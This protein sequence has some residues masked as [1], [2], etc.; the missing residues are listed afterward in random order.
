MSDPDLTLVE[1]DALL[2]ELS[3]RFDSSIFAGHTRDDH[4]AGPI[5]RRAKGTYLECAGLCADLSAHL[6]AGDRSLERRLT[7]RCPE[8]KGGA[9]N[10]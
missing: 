9:A 6:S 7:G 8:E 5:L 4:D 1:T 3:R 2:R 10:E